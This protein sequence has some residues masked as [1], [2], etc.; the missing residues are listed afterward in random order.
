MMEY[1]VNHIIKN[2]RF[3]YTPVISVTNCL[4]DDSN[5]AIHDATAILWIND[6][7]ISAY[8]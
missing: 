6:I 3:L 8:R 5:G 7:I 4:F 2:E 1:K